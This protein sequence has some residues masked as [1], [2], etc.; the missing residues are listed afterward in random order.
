MDVKL[1]DGTVIKGVPDGM[2]KSQLATKL[3]KAGRD[4]PKDWLQPSKSSPTM[5]KEDVLGS[6]TQQFL[7]GVG[8]S[9]VDIGRG[10]GQLVG[11]ESREDVEKARQLDKPLMESGYGK[12]G[13]IAG[14][15]AAT[16]PA[17]LIPGAAT[18]PGAAAVG[19]VQGALQPVG[20]DESRLSNIAVGGAAGAVGS[21]LGEVAAKGA[22]KLFASSQAKAAAHESLMKGKDEATKAAI[23]AGY[24]VPPSQANPTLFNQVLEGISG[25]IKTAQK[26]SEANQENTN[27]LI[28]Q[29]MGIGKDEPITPESLDSIRKTAGQSYEN[30]KRIGTPFKATPEYINNLE[31]IGSEW[32]AAAKEFPDLVKNEK[33]DTLINSLLQDEISPNAA[34]TVVKKL[35]YDAT[36]NLK[37]FDDPEKAA[38]GF[39]QRNAADAVEN[40]IDQNLRISGQQDLLKSFREA[41]KTIAKSYDVESALNEASGNVSAKKLGRLMDKGR[42]L[43]GELKMAARFAKAFPKA[44]QD[45]E[46]VGGVPA[47][48][49]LDYLAGMSGAGIAH[50]PMG[51]LAVLGRPIARKAVLSKAVQERSVASPN[52]RPSLASRTAKAITDKRKY[53]A[54]QTPTLA[55]AL[56]RPDSEQQ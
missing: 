29:A 5:T 30:I 24:K 9:F 3:Q 51:A 45:T 25:K 12:A 41:R 49:A 2:T 55:E 17:A 39:A 23:E 40:M 33:I 19:A 53:L 21:K 13:A 32:N 42:P 28:K 7:A 43:T 16:V 27:R 4:V 48:S 22:G 11:L 15:I 6:P 26:A 50:S 47:F 35:R 10:A 37:S 46:T 34:V 8:K 52:Y 18:V 14:D 44:A 38:L 20:K 36:K 54:T 56:V 31:K 1:P